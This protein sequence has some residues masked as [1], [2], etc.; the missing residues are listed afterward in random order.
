MNTVF[1]KEREQ[2]ETPVFSAS[3]FPVTYTLYGM[4][5]TTEVYKNITPCGVV[6]KYMNNMGDMMQIRKIGDRWVD[7]VFNT[8]TVL[9]TAIGKGIEQA[10]RL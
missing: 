2:T 8:S 9:S 1:F 7:V 5:G 6:Y 3:K 4:K 10:E